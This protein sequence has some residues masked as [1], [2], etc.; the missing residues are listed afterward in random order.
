MIAT[1]MVCIINEAVMTEYF[2]DCEVELA[3]NVIIGLLINPLR[4]S[5]MT[6][7]IE[8]NK[9]QVPFSSSVIILNIKTTFRR[10]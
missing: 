5:S 10:P 3:I 7:V 6:V 9:A 4:A 8:M 2:S 1:I